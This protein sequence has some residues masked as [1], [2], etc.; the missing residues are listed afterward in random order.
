MNV[1]VI[2]GSPKAEN[3]NSMKLTRAFLD[4]ARYD[5]DVICAAKLEI[6]PCLGCFACWEATPGEC[7][8]KDAA[9]QTLNRII[10]ADVIVWSFPLYYFSVPGTLKNLID[11][12]LP[13]CLPFMSDDASG[14]HK[15]RYDLSHQRYVVI[16]TCGFWTC[17]GNYGSVTAMFDRMYGNEN[18]TKIFCGQGELFRVPELKT[19]T[20]AYLEIVRRAGAEFAGGGITTGTQAE[21]ASPLYARE[22]FELMADASWGTPGNEAQATDGAL[23]FTRQMAAMYRPDGKERVL[24]FRFTDIG[25][26]Y[27]IALMPRGA[28]VII[29][30]FRPCATLVETPYSLWRSVA[31]GEIS[32]QD[33]LFQKK[34][35]VFGDF[36]V[37]LRW[38]ELFCGASADP[39]RSGCEKRLKTNMAVLLTPW[40]TIW[41]GFAAGPAIGGAL[42]IMAAA[43]VP[44][45]W[46]AF[47]PTIFE[48]ASVPIV[49]VLS[50]L[51]LIGA[52]MRIIVLASYGMFGLMW[53]VTAFA[54]VPLTAHYSLNRHGGDKALLNPLFIRTNRILTACWG[55]LYLLMPFWSYGLMTTAA[56]HFAWLVNLAAPVAMGWFTVWFQKWYPV[57]FLRHLSSGS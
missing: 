53:S 33:A 52:D 43:V 12:Q 55:V 39:Q 35:R 47:K 1:L 36:D 13:L 56:A 25:K 57:K 42:G 14:G 45:A 4:G 34:Y 54:K 29:D 3:S 41:A 7:V 40:M 28:S 51:A 6:K 32:G 9:A 26:T 44:L 2:N 46:L 22:A 18:Y 27:Q 17:E 21:L 24:E 49:A 37:L 31:R 23:R 19:R 20:D 11:R 38:D 50:L 8:I 10:G 15:P 48:R 30:D 16:S 5:A